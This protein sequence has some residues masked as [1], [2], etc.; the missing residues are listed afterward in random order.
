MMKPNAETEVYHLR[1]VKSSQKID[2]QN[3]LGMGQ[4]E[5]YEMG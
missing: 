4:Y 1:K 5:R 3:F 2:G